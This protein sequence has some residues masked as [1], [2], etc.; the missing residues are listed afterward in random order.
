M[1]ESLTHFANA[2]WPLWLMVVFIGIVAWAF[3]PKNKAKM[4]QHGQIPLRNDDLEA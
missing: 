4:E 2:V 3:W 1:L